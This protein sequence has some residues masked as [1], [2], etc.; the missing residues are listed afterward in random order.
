MLPQCWVTVDVHGKV[1]ALLLRVAGDPGRLAGAVLRGQC[2]M[3]DG[4]WRP[5][6]EW[7]PAE[8]LTQT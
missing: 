6:E 5:R 1:P 3:E 2:Y 8:N 7:L 4:R